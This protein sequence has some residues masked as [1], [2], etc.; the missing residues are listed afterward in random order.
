VFLVSSQL[1]VCRDQLTVVSMTTG[2]S[3]RSAKRLEAKVTNHNLTALKNR[4]FVGGGVSVESDRDF[5]GDQR[6]FGH[7]HRLELCPMCC[8][9][10]YPSA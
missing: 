8:M 9:K 7:G 6:V 1:F 3:L 10:D 2:P 5:P 4:I